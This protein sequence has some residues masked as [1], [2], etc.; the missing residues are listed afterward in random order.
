[1]VLSEAGPFAPL[2]FVKPGA[3]GALR[4]VEE[5]DGDTDAPQAFGR[6]CAFHGQMG[7]FS[8][9]LAYILSHGADG[10]AQAS[11]DA[12]QICALHCCAGWSTC[13]TRRSARPADACTRRCSAMM[14]LPKVLTLDL[15]KG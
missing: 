2:P 14:A 12:V 10:L 13:S 5:T 15:A 8:R 7:M 11:G 1:V 4:L 3:D 6:M 9:A